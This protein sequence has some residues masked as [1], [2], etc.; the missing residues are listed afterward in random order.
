MTT[1][2]QASMEMVGS[3][4]DS[5]GMVKVTHTWPVCAGQRGR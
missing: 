5:G 1:S 4:D 2:P 3:I